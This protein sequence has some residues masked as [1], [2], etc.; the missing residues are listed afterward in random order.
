MIIFVADNGT[1][2][3]AAL[4]NIKFSSMGTGM[5][6]YLK[7]VNQTLPNLGNVSSQINYGDWGQDASASP[8]SGFKTSE[9][10]GGTRVPFIFKEP[11]V[12]SS[13][14]ASNS[15]NPKMIKAFAYVT[16]LTPTFLD[17]QESRLHIMEVK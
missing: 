17:M 1:S 16:D 14:S 7:L 9:Y 8:L 6:D 4:L 11:G 3:P 10:E 15:S 5:A 13:P 2:E 12:S